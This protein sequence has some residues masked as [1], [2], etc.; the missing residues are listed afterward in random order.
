MEGRK[1]FRSIRETIW[2]ISGNH[3]LDGFCHQTQRNGGRLVFALTNHSEV[4]MGDLDELS[5]AVFGLGRS[6]ENGDP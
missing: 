5:R 3:D 4:G 2:E 1:C 6:A